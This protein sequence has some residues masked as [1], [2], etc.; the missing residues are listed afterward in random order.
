V[1]AAIERTGVLQRGV[2]V[3]LNLHGS[4]LKNGSRQC[5]AASS[6]DDASDVRHER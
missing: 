4:Q 1:H 3:P 2:V 6:D 5:V